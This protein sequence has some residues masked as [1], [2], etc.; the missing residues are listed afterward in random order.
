M[1]G[2]ATKENRVGRLS[3]A[4]KEVKK[5]PQGSVARPLRRSDVGDKKR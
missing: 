3:A 1:K 4:E 2:N 5:N